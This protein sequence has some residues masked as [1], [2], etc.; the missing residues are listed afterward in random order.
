MTL[1]G[2]R[3]IQYQFLQDLPTSLRRDP[4][5]KRRMT[6]YN[7]QQRFLSTKRRRKKPY[8]VDE[9]VC[10]ANLVYVVAEAALE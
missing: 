8:S 5:Q 9:S 3:S 4:S 2:I 7:S 6:F 10:R 1:T